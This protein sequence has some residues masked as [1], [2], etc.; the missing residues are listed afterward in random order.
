M[1]GRRRGRW[2][3]GEAAGDAGRSDLGIIGRLV[4][5][6]FVAQHLDAAE[7]LLEQRDAAGVGHRL[8]GADMAVRQ[9]RLR[10]EKQAASHTDFVE[11]PGAVT[12]SSPLHEARPFGARV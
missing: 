7:N 3:D 8:A 11:Q 5:G 4:F 9:W 1:A 12:T 2:Q 6:L 10:P